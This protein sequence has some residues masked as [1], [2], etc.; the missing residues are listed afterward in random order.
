M[1]A[2]Y[3]VGMDDDTNREQIYRLVKQLYGERSALV[4]GSAPR[5]K[6]KRITPWRLR[7]LVR[8]LLVAFVAL[9][10]RVDSDESWEELV[11][12]VVVS[13]EQQAFV[14]RVAHRPLRLVRPP[15]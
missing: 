12:T 7:A 8:D 5:R 6:D 4:H 9:R 11:R 14:T 15:K 1:R 2:A 13:S 10:Q 3:L